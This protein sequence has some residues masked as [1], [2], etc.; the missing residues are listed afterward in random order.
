M[1]TLLQFGAGNIGRGF[2]APTFAAAGWQVIFVEVA[3]TVVAALRQRGGYRLRLVDGTHETVQAV[4][5]VGVIDGRDADA[6]ADAVAACDLA[7]TAV[8]LGVLPRLGA[9]I[10]AGLTRR[11]VQLDILVCENGAQAHAILRDAILAA[12]PGAAERLGCVRTSIGRMIPPPQAGEDVLDLRVEPY[13]HLPVE[14]AAFR[15]ALPVVAGIE[16]VDDM[17]LVQAQKL[18]LHN[19]THACLAYGGHR[20]G[21]ATI[22]DCMQ[23]ETLVARTRNVAMA[24]CAAL[25]SRFSAGAA[26]QALVDDLL[27]R[28]RNRAL[29][30]P[31]GRVAR[32]P[33]RKLAA[34]DR[35]VGAA[36]LCLAHGAAIEPIAAAIADACAYVASPDEPRAA[37]WN[38]LS[39]EARLLAATGLGPRDPLVAAVRRAMAA[40]RMRAAGLLLRDDE[41]ATLEIADFG[42]DRFADLG[43]AI[44]VY[45]NT[46]RCC[47]KELMLLP[48]QTCPEHLHP[49]V[50]GEAGKEE[51]FRVRSGEVFMH[52]P[53]PHDAAQREAALARLPA[54]LRGTVSVFRTLHLRAGEQCTLLPDTAHW[55]TAGP[56]GA[57]V[58]EFSTRSRDEADIF[59]DPAIVRVP[60]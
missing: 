44:H 54:D 46:A 41:V 60:A 11:T 24:V 52:L 28:Y 58:S 21:H 4:C 39:P 33:W 14:R 9:V 25:E 31:V 8:G 23:D 56:D 6:V 12:A 48:G 45:V 22:P 59:T 49:A 29:A 36:R 40:E 37:A 38:A 34:D 16:P 57:V 50:D 35:L 53:G 7:A 43:L 42:L 26:S 15:G 10:A 51:T 2:I 3:P 20:R 55:F 13:A 18:Y 19:L 32:D 17:D 30:D 47:A 27:Q 5:D 1:P